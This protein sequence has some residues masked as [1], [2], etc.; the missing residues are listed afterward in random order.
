MTTWHYALKL[1]HWASGCDLACQLEYMKPINENVFQ[2]K[3]TSCRAGISFPF[4]KSNSFIIKLHNPFKKDFGKLY[5]VLTFDK[6]IILMGH[7]S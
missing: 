3:I 7:L 1:N 2:R 4:Q 5:L 6:V